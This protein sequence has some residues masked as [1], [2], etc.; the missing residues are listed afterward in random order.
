MTLNKS[1][2]FFPLELGSLKT[3]IIKGTSGNALDLPE[4]LGFASSGAS[5]SHSRWQ[6]CKLTYD[7]DGKVIARDFL[8]RVDGREDNDFVHKWDD[9]VA[10]IA[11]NQSISLLQNYEFLPFSDD[12]GN[13]QISTALTGGAMVLTQ[14]SAFGLNAAVLDDTNGFS[15]A[16]SGANFDL[17]ENWEITF[18]INTTNAPAADFMYLLSTLSVDDLLGWAVVLNNRNEL[19]IVVAGSIITDDMTSNTAPRGTASSSG[20]LGGPV[21]FRCFDRDITQEW[22]PDNSVSTGWVQIELNNGLSAFTAIDYAITSAD[23]GPTYSPKNWTVQ[24][25]LGGSGLSIIDTI[26]NESGWGVNERRIYTIDSPGNFDRYRLDVTANNG[27]QNL[28]ISQWELLD[29]SSPITPLFQTW[30]DNTYHEVKLSASGGFL[31]VYYDGIRQVSALF[32]KNI[33]ASTDLF[34]GSKGG[35]TTN[36]LNGLIDNLSIVKN[37]VSPMT[38]SSYVVPSVPFVPGVNVAFGV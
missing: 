22:V 2:P 27:G 38:A 29:S 16:D 12:S 6:I 28:R 3:R 10:F 13:D 32:S 9:L 31:R 23:D 34:V 25:D 19:N 26:N 21:A 24:A 30:V 15:I 17:G 37:P 18:R 5:E 8:Q 14:N 1:N 4:Y 36:R 11:G 35:I 7:S 33:S 20:G